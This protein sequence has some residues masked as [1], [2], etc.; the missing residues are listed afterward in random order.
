MAEMGRNYT[1]QSPWHLHMA[2]WLVLTN[3][4]QV[5]EPYLGHQDS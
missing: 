1:P 2:M 4:M 5:E 3:E